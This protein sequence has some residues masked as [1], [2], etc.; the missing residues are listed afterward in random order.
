MKISLDYDNTITLDPEFW[1]NF[2][3]LT[4]EFN[5]EIVIVTYRF[6]STKNIINKIE[7]Q[8]LEK[9]ASD[10]NVEIIY[11][12]SQQKSTMFTPEES[13][14]VWVDDDPKF[15]P[16]LTTMKNFLEWFRK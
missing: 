8:R 5:H 11:S 7:N 14:D 12:N 15:I 10:N 16:S 4:R 1:S 9:F 13:P 2:I 3:K 6:D